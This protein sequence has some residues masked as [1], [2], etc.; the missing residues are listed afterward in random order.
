MNT[1][2]ETLLN[3]ANKE[4]ALNYFRQ[5]AADNVDIFDQ[6]ESTRMGLSGPQ[7]EMISAIF[8]MIIVGG[9]TLGVIK[10]L[11]LLKQ[12]IFPSR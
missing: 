1:I 7:G 5:L 6:F 3:L 11:S 12:K 9:A 10:L 4:L 2:I 8:L